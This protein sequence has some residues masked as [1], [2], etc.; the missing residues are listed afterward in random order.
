MWKNVFG[1]KPAG[2][3]GQLY[4]ARELDWHLLVG[5]CQQVAPALTTVGWHTKG[6]GAGGALALAD[7]LEKEIEAK[8][9]DAYAG[10]YAASGLDTNQP[11]PCDACSGS[12][13]RTATVPFG[14]GGLK[15]VA[16]SKEVKCSSCE[17]VRFSAEC[18]AAFAAFLRESGGFHPLT[19]RYAPAG[20]MPANTEV[21]MNETMTDELKK[22]IEKDELCAEVRNFAHGLMRGGRPPLDV[23]EALINGTIAFSGRIGEHAMRRYV[24][25]CDELDYVSR[26]SREKAEKRDDTV[27]ILS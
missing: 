1:R 21:T 4:Q 25:E 15:E 24:T 18:V 22:N 17:G 23:V 14:T 6:L 5:F 7:V 20:W 26:R 13:V 8:R 11:E 10:R 9:T 3:R 16:Y 2:E 27:G 19:T 12:G